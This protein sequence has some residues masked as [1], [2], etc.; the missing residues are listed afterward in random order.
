MATSIQKNLISSN[1]K[2]AESFTQGHLALPPA[3]KYLVRMQLPTTSHEVYPDNQ[4]VTCMDARI[5]PAAAFGIGLGDAH[6]IRNVRAL[7]P[8]CPS[9][10]PEPTS[11]P[12][13]H[14]CPLGRSICQR[15]PPLNN[16]LRTTPRHHRDP[17]HQAHRLW[18]AHIPK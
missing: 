4:V 18:H 14:N 9:P 1:E 8:T 7:S 5:D 16:H 11:I 6:V 15:C 13:T 10:I 12:R 3:K 2:Y 17:A